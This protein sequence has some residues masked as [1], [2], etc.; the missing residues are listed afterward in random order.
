MKLGENDTIEAVYY[1]YPEGEGENETISY[2]S[3]NLDLHKLK[4]GKRDTKGTKIRA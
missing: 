4:S 2:K 1:A 3:R